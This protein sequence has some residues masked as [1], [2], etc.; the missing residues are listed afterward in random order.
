MV[1]ISTPLCL[2]GKCK[3]HSSI[4]RMF[5]VQLDRKLI[6][7]TSTYDRTKLDLFKVHNLVPA[8]PSDRAV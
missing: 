6:M 4:L 3:V 8:G 2:K 7:I 5:A 1:K